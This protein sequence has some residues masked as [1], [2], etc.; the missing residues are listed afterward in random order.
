LLNFH[1]F[2]AELIT[3]EVFLS[4]AQF[5]KEIFPNF[6]RRFLQLKAQALEV[7]NDQVIAKAFKALHTR[8]LHSHLVRERPKTVVELYEEF[9]KLSKSEVLHFCKFEQQTETTKHD[10]APRPP[11][12]SDNQRSYPKQVNSIDFDGCGPPENWEK[13]FG[14]PPQERSQRTF[15][16]KQ[17]QYSQRGRAPG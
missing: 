4:C 13:N 8:P 5:K 17:N 3:E 10:E 2:Q 16:Y 9:T 11:H 1:G 7:S 12:Y 15:D 14:P 6:Y